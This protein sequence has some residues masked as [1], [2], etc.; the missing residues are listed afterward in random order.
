MPSLIYKESE[1]ATAPVVQKNIA[2]FTPEGRPFSELDLNES[3]RSG[4]QKA[5]F[6]RCTPIQDRCL[7]LTLDGRDVAGQAQTGTGK[8]AAFL[9]TVFN[10]LLGMPDRKP[11]SPAALIIVPTREL[12]QQIFDEAMI[13]GGDTGLSVTAVFGGVD[14]EKQANQLRRGTDIIIGTPGRFIDY[15]KQKIIPMK[16]IRMLVIDEAD[17]MFDMGFIKDLRFM[18]RRLPPFDRR[19]SM[20]FSATLSYRVLELAYEH[21]NVP[22]EIYIDPD[23]RTVD[24]VEQKVYHV[25]QPEK[26]PL[27]LGIL[28]REPW[29]RVLI[30]CNTKIQVE[31]LAGKLT[32]N[33]YPAEGITGNLPQRKRLQLMKRYKSGE[34]KILVATDVASRGIHVEDISHVINYDIPQDKE[35]YVHRIGRTA[36]A[37]KKGKAITLA[38]EKWGA[39]PGADRSLYRTENPD[40]LVRRWISGKRHGS[41]L[42]EKPPHSGEKTERQKRRT[43]EKTSGVRG[44]GEKTPTAIRQAGKRKPPSGRSRRV[45]LR[46]IIGC[47]KTTETSKQKKT[48][49]K[50]KP[51]QARSRRSLESISGFRVDPD[52]PSPHKRRTLRIT[53]NVYDPVNDAG[54][55]VQL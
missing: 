46:R 24:T 45:P 18:L 7:P 29:E 15:M 4:I 9:I 25:G 35:D 38:C 36:R 21:M 30:F 10:R 1:Q 54:G 12:A 14:Y 55:C 39:A 50:K 2:P 53:E 8:T 28:K 20:L 32:G 23:V 16:N 40:R 11:G 33:G 22:E 42:S 13:L 47:F 51:L 49:T 34:L 41:P 44:S 5:G 3:V 31:R 26:L 17:R 48:P 43:A 37:G 52:D 27:L 19:Q 6:T